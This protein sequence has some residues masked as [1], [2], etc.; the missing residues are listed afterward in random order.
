MKL[1]LEVAHENPGVLKHPKSDVLFDQYGESSLDFILR[2]WNNQYSDTPQIL[3][4]Q[5]Y[6]SIFEKFKEHGIEIPYPQ[7][8]LHLKSGFGQ[9]PALKDE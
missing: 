4:S 5:L 2:I 6:Y 9:M 7:R 3:K 8:D 1:L